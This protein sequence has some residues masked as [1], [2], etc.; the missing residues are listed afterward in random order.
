[1]KLVKSKQKNVRNV[2]NEDANI[3]VEP[4]TPESI[5]KMIQKNFEKGISRR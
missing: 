4:I 2:S 5:K 1:M 3:N